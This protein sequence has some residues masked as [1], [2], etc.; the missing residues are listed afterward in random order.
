MWA[1]EV[2]R[3]RHQ[4]AIHVSIRIPHY[5][6]IWLLSQNTLKSLQKYHITA[7]NLEKRGYEVGREK[8]DQTLKEKEIS[9]SKKQERE[10][11]SKTTIK[12]GV[13]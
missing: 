1:L 3:S 12:H 5:G 6:F 9:Y 11:V 2:C 7:E 4:T 10:Q 8:W 13:F